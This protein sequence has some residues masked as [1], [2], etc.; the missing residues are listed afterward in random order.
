MIFERFIQPTAIR[1]ALNI[2]A[3]LLVA[4]ALLLLL[5]RGNYDENALVVIA[6][7]INTSLLVIM[8]GV[9]GAALYASKPRVL[10]RVALLVLLLIFLLFNPLYPM[11][12]T[13]AISSINQL[14]I[15]FTTTAFALTFFARRPF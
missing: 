1:T 8:Y 10:N 4:S 15:I 3:A 2:G 5:M 9:A 7:L 14:L 12:Y 11:I 6:G 13:N